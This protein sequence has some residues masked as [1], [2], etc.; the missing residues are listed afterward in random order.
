MPDFTCMLEIVG[1]KKDYFH[2]PG[3]GLPGKNCPCKN[4]KREYSEKYFT[5]IKM[6]SI[7]YADSKWSAR[8]PGI[9][10][11]KPS[12]SSPNSIAISCS[13]AR[14]IGEDENKRFKKPGGT[15]SRYATSHY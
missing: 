13:N 2:S 6:L 7:I 3:Q 14:G 10:L 15:S 1:A 12:C 8:T 9:W 4:T 11:Q 5:P